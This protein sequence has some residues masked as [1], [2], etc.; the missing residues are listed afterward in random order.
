[1]SPASSARA[2]DNGD[3]DRRDRAGRAHHAAAHL[4]QHPPPGGA[5][6][7]GDRLRRRP[8]RRRDLSM[9]LGADTFPGSQLRRAV[10][11]AHRKGVVI[12]VASGNEFA[13]HHHS[14]PGRD[15][16]LAVGGVNPDTADAA[17]TTATWR[18]SATTSR[19]TPPTPT[20]DRTST[21]SRRP[22]CRRS[23]WGGGT[24]LKWSGT[25]AATPHVAGAAALVAARGKQLGL[26]ALGRGDDP[27]PPDDRRRPQGSGAAATRPAGTCCR[28]GGG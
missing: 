21:S 10:A 17:R 14:A 28:A 11:Y 8:R 20:T 15:D 4:R 5:A 18:R 27:D 25:S 12:A 19:S 3:R 23:S 24:D 6:G 9:S 26:H 7:R 2:A 16:V 22:R 13:F 1:M